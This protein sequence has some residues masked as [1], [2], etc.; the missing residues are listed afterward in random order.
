MLKFLYESSP[1]RVR[2]GL[3]R[4]GVAVLLVGLTAAVLV[5]RDS[6]GE[7]RSTMDPNSN[8]A[9]PLAPI[10]SAKQSRQIE[11]YYGKTG[12]LFERWCEEAQTMLHGK[13]LARLIG[14]AS[15]AIASGC[16]LMARRIP[17]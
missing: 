8:P 10:D 1:A 3:N 14:I 13:P 2:S 9:A 4:A 7:P 12:I 5:W 15:L 16:F 6:S 11:I 17:V